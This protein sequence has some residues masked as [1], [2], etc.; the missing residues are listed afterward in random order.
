MTLAPSRQ[1]SYSQLHLVKETI[2]YTQTTDTGPKP[3]EPGFWEFQ[4][5]KAQGK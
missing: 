3:G 2:M 4:R 1:R 5:A